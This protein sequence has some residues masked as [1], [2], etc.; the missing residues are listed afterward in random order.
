[1]VASRRNNHQ[2][3]ALAQ[4]PAHNGGVAQRTASAHTP[5]P[6]VVVIAF[7]VSGVIHLIRPEVFTPIIPKPLQKWARPLVVVSGVAEIACA[8]GLVAPPTRRLAGA[9]AAALLVAVWPANAQMSINLG[10]RA[11]RRKNLKSW[12]GFVVSLARLPLQL[13]L[14]AQ[15]WRAV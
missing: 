11:K 8:A 2:L 7:A 9:A 12:A 15:A 4:N 5:V 10:R 1:M 14:I 13:P 6:W 3:L